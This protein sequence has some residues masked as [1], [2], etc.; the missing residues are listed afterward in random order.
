VHTL[1]AGP[2]NVVQMAAGKKKLKERDPEQRALGTSGT[3]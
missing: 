1:H 2:S 3:N